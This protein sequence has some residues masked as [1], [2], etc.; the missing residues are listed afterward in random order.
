M[1]SQD[2]EILRA[3]RRGSLLGTL[4][5]GVGA[6][7]ANAANAAES[8]V[9][10][11]QQPEGD[12]SQTEAT[13]QPAGTSDLKSKLNGKLA[14]VTG[15]ARGIGRSI[16]VEFAANGADVVGLDICGPAS[17]D[18]LYPHSTQADLDETEWLVKSYGRRFMPVVADIRDIAALRAAAANV[19]SQMGQIHIVVADAGIQLFKPLLEMSDTQW[20]DVIDVNLN[21]TANTIRAFGPALVI[22]G[23]G[24]IIVLASMQ[25]RYGTKNGSSY[26]ASKWG[27]IG[28][29]K[30]AALELGASKITVN[31]VVPGL[32]DTP[33]TRNEMRWSLAIAAATGHVV[34]DP[35]EDQA[36][37]A[38]KPHL[39]LGVPWLTPDQV[40]P[41]AVFLASDGAA[42][43]TGAT[44]EVTGGDS[45]HDTA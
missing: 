30:S 9:P 10:N 27:I 36:V 45:A 39:P 4:A 24:R 28:L 23:G 13:R 38:L 19:A 7:G 33:M 12:T 14:V 18:T 15:A 26:S 41:V 17:T 21:G 32:I 44:Y 3:D 22:G 8:R 20:H 11:S 2:D 37:A 35:T 16:A 43:V 1:S 34:E 6:L 25:G 42:M 40:A 29:M 5:A 31:A